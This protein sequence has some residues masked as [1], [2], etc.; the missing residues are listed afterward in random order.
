MI[1]YIDKINL[2]KTKMKN[3]AKLLAIALFMGFGL[4]T[5]VS[6]F[7]QV[8][9][10]APSGVPPSGNVNPTFNG[11]T[12]TGEST[13]GTLSAGATTVSSGS[14]TGDLS[15]TGNSTATGNMDIK[16]VLKN[17]KQVGMLGYPLSIQDFVEISYGLKFSNYAGWNLSVEDV[18]I[19]ANGTG[20]LIIDGDVEIRGNVTADQ[21]GMIYQKSDLGVD[22]A[23]NNAN[24]QTVYCDS[25]DFVIGCAAGF[26]SSLNTTNAAVYSQQF[27]SS[28]GNFG[29]KAS[30]WNKTGST[31]K[32][33]V[34]PSCIRTEGNWGG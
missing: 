24:S 13:L 5:A 19:G 18:D 12:V 28:A 3:S 30:G 22:V 33:Y 23:N 26:D 17:S 25:G 20:T 1:K 32:L 21:F 9:N 8:I 11:L 34:M 31:Q 14:V 10:A 29:C 27:T 6:S 2:N 15:V 7:P 16:G 4:F